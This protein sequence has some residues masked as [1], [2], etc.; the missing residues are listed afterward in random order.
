MVQVRR[1][2]ANQSLYALF[3]SLPTLRGASNRLSLS[4]VLD[5]STR[6][7]LRRVDQ[8]QQGRMSDKRPGGAHYVFNTHHYV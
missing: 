2:K 4:T 6:R 3:E 1:S 8:D 7:E 5:E